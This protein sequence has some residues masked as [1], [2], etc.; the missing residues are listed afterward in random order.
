MKILTVIIIL[1]NIFVVQLTAEQVLKM[2][3]G[4]ICPFQCIP[5]NEED[6]LGLINE[7]TVKIFTEEGFSIDLVNVPFVRAIA[8]SQEGHIDIM[9]TIYKNE[10]PNLLYPE[11]HLAVAREVFFV[12]NESKWK[13]TNIQSLDEISGNEQII[14]K[15]GYDFGSELFEDYMNNNQAKFYSLYGEDIFKKAIQILLAKR[16]QVAIFDQSIFSHTSNLLG[17]ADSFK[18]VGALNEGKK[19]Y[20]GISVRTPNAPELI[21][22]FDSKLK[23]MKSDGSYQDIISK[24]NLMTFQ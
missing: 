17:V 9:A 1:C 12:R 8:M 4:D 20:I 18:I 19:L 13:Y 24:Y 3:S 7:I 5:D 11:E 21:K 22:I 6:Y 15:K 10:I 23:K 14:V 2:H 16:A